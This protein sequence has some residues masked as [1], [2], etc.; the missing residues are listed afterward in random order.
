VGDLRTLLEPATPAWRLSALPPA[1]RCAEVDASPVLWLG[2]LIR[3]CFAWRR[4]GG[5]DEEGEVFAGLRVDGH[6]QADAAG[7]DH[8]SRRGSIQAEPGRE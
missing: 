4:W 1:S 7:M 6:G 2:L 3:C 8:A 5:D